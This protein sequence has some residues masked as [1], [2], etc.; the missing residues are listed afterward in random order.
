LYNKN[1]TELIMCPEGKTTG[2]F[3]IPNSVTTI[4]AEAFS[5]CKLTGVTIPN[6]VTS[7]GDSAFSGCGLNS[8]T[9]PGSITSI[10][11]WA[12]YCTNL[13]S[14]TFQGTIARTNFGED[15]DE[16]GSPFPG[17]LRTKFYATNSADGTPGTYLRSSTGYK[18]TWMKQ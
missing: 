16:D 18:G 12:F 10:G 9:I 3:N 1:K 7:I 17:D 8:V 11:G 15:Y 5:G 13:T 4:G 14:V 6:S 2:A